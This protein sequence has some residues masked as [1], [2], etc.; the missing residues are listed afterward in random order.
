MAE[1]VR[2]SDGSVRAYKVRYRDAAGQSRSRSFDTA[3]EALTFEE[4][5]R[6][7]ERKG[8][9]RPAATRL[10]DFILRWWNEVAV[11]DLAPRTQDT[12]LSAW[13]A[14]C[15]RIGHVPLDLLT[16]RTFDNF[17]RSALAD[18]AGPSTIS[19]MMAMVQTA[20]N[21]AILW[22]ELEPPN[23]V[24]LVKKPPATPVPVVVPDL[25]AVERVLLA[26]DPQPG[27]RALVALLAY[28]GL[29]PEEARALRWRDVQER[30][31]LVAATAEPDGSITPGLKNGWPFRSV[32]L[33]RPLKADLAALRLA[34]GRPDGDALIWPRPA[35]DHPEDKPAWTDY[36]YRNWRRRTYL[37]VATLFDLPRPGRP[38][39]LRHL[40]ASLLIASGYSVADVA[41]QMGH[42]PDMTLK[43][44]T[45]VI[46]ELRGKPPADPALTI[47]NARTTVQREAA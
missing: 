43:T 13:N 28:A 39:T 33:L 15:D 3:V 26:L 7:L 17:K 35:K 21:Q 32:D 4:E 19:K 30:T 41:D 20:L 47:L 12:Y 1:R 9:R 44:Y 18:G 38:Y 22:G 36:D 2:R 23:P 29:R 14:H 31:L 42:S 11:H 25:T 5:T 10:D 6:R 46:A 45:H 37:P 27:S 40:F 24:Q 8:N 34:D 16:A